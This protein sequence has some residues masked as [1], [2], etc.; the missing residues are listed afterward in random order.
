M[1]FC[2]LAAPKIWF[3]FPYFHFLVNTRTIEMKNVRKMR[4]SGVLTFLL[5]EI[6]PPI[7]NFDCLSANEANKKTLY[8]AHALCGW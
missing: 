7:A 1:A 2:A 5:L 8:N 3:N 4:N 6:S